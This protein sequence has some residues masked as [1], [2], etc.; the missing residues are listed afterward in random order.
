MTWSRVHT[1]ISGSW[2]CHLGVSI[3][4]IEAGIGGSG[5]ESSN[6]QSS[7]LGCLLHDSVERPQEC[8]PARSCW[9][10]PHSCSA[11]CHSLDGFETLPSSFCSPLL[12]L[13]CHDMQRPHSP[14]AEG[15][16]DPPPGRNDPGPGLSMAADTPTTF[17]GGALMVNGAFEA[18]RTLGPLGRVDYADGRGRRLGTRRDIAAERV[19]RGRSLDADMSPSTQYFGQSLRRSR[20]SMTGLQISEGPSAACGDDSTPFILRSSELYHRG[21]KAEVVSWL[22][23]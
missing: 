18:P 15:R 2:W 16:L 22:C 17:L 8:S 7:L 20:G 4:E 1:E 6:G 5:P 14:S 11:I 10:Y 19:T 23:L 21:R 12:A 13:A 9:T 3:L